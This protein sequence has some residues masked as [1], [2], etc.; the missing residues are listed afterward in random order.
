MLAAGSQN[1]VLAK[2]DIEVCLPRF[3]MLPPV[4]PLVGAF[5]PVKPRCATFSQGAEYD[6]LPAAVDAMCESLDMVQLERHEKLLYQLWRTSNET[7]LEHSHLR[8]RLHE[9]EKQSRQVQQL[10][11]A[12]REIRGRAAKGTC[13]T[14]VQQLSS[15]CT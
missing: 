5:D 3:C 14:H 12:L 8:Y 7:R 15:A 4:P 10:E 11:V 1:R 6:A 2:M 13:R 9:F